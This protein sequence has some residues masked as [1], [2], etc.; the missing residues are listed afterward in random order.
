[1]P[2]NISPLRL[3]TPWR[4]VIILCRKCGKKRDDGFGPKR[5]DSLKTALRQALRD[6]GRRRQVDTIHII[7]VGTDGSGAMRTLLGHYAGP[8]LAVTDWA[9]TDWAV[10]DWAGTGRDTVEAA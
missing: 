10:S 7:P 5:K 1:M 8:H 2:G 9:V 3:A 4:D 6:T